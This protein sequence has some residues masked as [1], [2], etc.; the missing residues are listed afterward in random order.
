[1]RHNRKMCLLAP[2]IT[3]LIRFVQIA[4]LGEWDLHEYFYVR[5]AVFCLKTKQIYNEL[6]PVKGKF[7][8]FNQKNWFR[9]RF[10][11]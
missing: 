3:P 4:E 7:A 6:R 10:Y 11:S 8:D 1:M 9:C 2:R 5:F